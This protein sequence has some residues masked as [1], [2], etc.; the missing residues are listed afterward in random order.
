M[1][2]SELFKKVLAEYATQDV[3]SFEKIDK[4][5][6]SENYKVTTADGTFFLKKHRGSGAK[7]IDS[8]EQAEQC[9]ANGGIPVVLPIKNKN[10]KLH[11]VV[12]GSIY[13]LYPFVSGKQYVSGNIPLEMASKMGSMLAQAHLVTVDGFTGAYNEDLNFSLRPKDDALSRM[14]KIISSI[15]KKT[16]FD[17]IAIRG[18]KLKKTL[19]QNAAATIESIDSAPRTICLGD[20]YPDNVFFD[21]DNNIAHIFDLDMAGPGPRIIELVRSALLTCCWYV[22]IPENIQK[23]KAFV[24]EYY[25]MYPFNE[26]ELRDAL[27]FYFL[28]AIRSTWREKLHYSENDF[29]SDADYK[30][31]LGEI[32][33]LDKN[34]QSLLEV[35]NPIN[36]SMSDIISL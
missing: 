15:P 33:Y 17:E 30:L 16:E 31:A 4:G 12:D 20:Y 23:A 14:D 3:V 8:I 32:E 21:Q 35:V 9:F 29:R 36:S 28:K 26:Q 24:Y 34:R 11:S 18:L 7:R 27:E 1:M 10:A 13:V 5:F 2:T 19:L 25:K 6:A 22:Y